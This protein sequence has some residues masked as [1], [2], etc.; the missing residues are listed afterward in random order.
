VISVCMSASFFLHQLW[1]AASG[2]PEHHPACRVVFAGGV[3][4]E[5]GGIERTQAMP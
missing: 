2:R 5:F 1:V 3:P 4:A